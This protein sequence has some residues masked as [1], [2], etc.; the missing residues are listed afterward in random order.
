MAWA[1]WP[2]CI[3]VRSVPIYTNTTLVGLL[4]ANDMVLCY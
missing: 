3:T 2:L 4:N 1:T